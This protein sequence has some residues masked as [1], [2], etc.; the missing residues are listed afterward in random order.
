MVRPRE[1]TAL[2]V[3]EYVVILWL[4]AFDCDSFH[5]HATKSWRCRGCLLERERSD[6]SLE[7]NAGASLAI[8]PKMPLM[9]A[10]ES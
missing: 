6:Q 7:G 1:R 3:P 2:K 10:G 5:W 4:S 8:V 9:K